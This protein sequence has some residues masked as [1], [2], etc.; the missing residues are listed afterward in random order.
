MNLNQ[1][2]A[3][4]A[5]GQGLGLSGASERLHI[6]QP[7]VS[8]NLTN[9]ESELDV[10]L[11]NR[12]K[13]RLEL[14]ELGMAA[15]RRAIALKAEL[16]ALRDELAALD[17]GARDIVRFD[18]SPAIFPTLAPE[19]IV[20]VRSEFPNSDI[21]LIGNPAE[22][23]VEKQ[24]K[25][26]RGESDLLVTHISSAERQHW[27]NYQH[28]L[29]IRLLF[30]THKS[31]PASQLNEPR[32]KDLA[33]YNWITPGPTGPPY[34]LL[35]K[36]FQEDGAQLPKNALP[37]AN[38]GVALSILRMGGHIAAVPIH[39]ACM[40]FDLKD[41]HIINVKT[42]PLAWDLSII[43][44]ENTQLSP[45]SESFRQSLLERALYYEKHPPYPIPG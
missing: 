36:A 27:A 38:R 37:M 3:L 40:E 7:A 5:I 6:S 32:L 15:Y 44:R 24:E 30:L 13:Y 11:F 23:P 10:S 14:N 18:C 17:A 39:E 45:A 34:F 16:N 41:F 19:S 1:I 29:D 33:E 2:E 4:I 26:R 35:N 9:L 22:D 25:L 43:T 12:D 8:K 42:R 28:L 31:H 20:R 21:Q